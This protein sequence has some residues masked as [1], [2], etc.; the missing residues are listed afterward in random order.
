MV[1]LGD[2][3]GQ[4]TIGEQLLVWGVLNQ[5]FGA[6]INP[7]LVDIQQATNSFDANV[8]LTPQ[9]L[10]VA[11]VRGIVADAEGTSEAAKSGIGSGRFAQLQQLA[12]QPADLSYIVAAYQ[13]SMGTGGPGGGALVDIDTALADLGISEQYRPL[14]KALAVIIPS[15]DDV[16]T[17]WLEGQIEAAEAQSRLAATGLDPTWIQTGYNARGQAPTPVQALELWN[18]GIIVESGTGPDAT[19]YEQAF[20]EGP[21]RNKWLDAFKALRFYIP[22]PRT[23]TALSKEGALTE[24]QAAQYLADNGLDETLTAIYLAGAHK[25]TSTASKELSEAQTVDLYEGK[26]I[27][28]AEAS[29]DLVS[30][31]YSATT[32][33]LILA[34]ADQRQAASSVKS[35]VTRLQNLYLAGTNS[36]TVTQSALHSLGLTDDNVSNLIA[37]W[38]LEQTARVKELTEGQIVAAW[39]YG[40]FGTNTDPASIGTAVTRLQTLGYSQPDALLLLTARIHSPVTLAGVSTG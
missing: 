13:R 17:A 31:G 8:A 6:A 14:V 37:T 35:A 4:G 28:E 26:L 27:T 19:S 12:Q 39:F 5:L 24:A 18:R 1:A 33:Q 2:L 23:V 7:A 36:L 32:A 22:P 16:Y 3:F 20:L 34:L 11:V 38:N 9:Q 21:W 30:I 15:A 29:A 10:A 40:G 25:T